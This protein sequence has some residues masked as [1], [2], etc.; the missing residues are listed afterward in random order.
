MLKHRQ[1]AALP[2][3]KGVCLPR[4]ERDEDVSN[5]LSLDISFRAN[6]SLPTD[7]AKH[8]LD[9]CSDQAHVLYPCHPYWYGY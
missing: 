4:D 5:Q 3:G 2:K 6:H 7:Y 1:Q 8:S 9:D